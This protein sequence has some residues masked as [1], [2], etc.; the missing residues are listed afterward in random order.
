MSDKPLDPRTTP[1][2]ELPDALRWQLRALRR[3]TPPARDLWS[4]I[5]ARLGE[6]ASPQ[7]EPAPVDHLAPIV[8]SPGDPS[9]AEAAPIEAVPAPQVI[10]LRS[11]ESSRP[12]WL[13]PM[14]LAAS[15]A[16]LAVAL[17]VMWKGGAAVDGTAAGDV[18]A[19]GGAGDQGPSAS[20]GAGIADVGTKPA[21]GRVVAQ[22]STA[23]TATGMADAGK[24]PADSR[25]GDRNSSAPTDTG[26][27]HAAATPA[28]LVQ[29]EADG[30]TRQ[31]QAA[32]REIEPVSQQAVALK[33][34]FDELD[35]NTA[36][37]LDAMAHDPDSRLLLEQLRRTYA[38][39]LA[40][41][42]RVAYT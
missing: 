2:G 1:D 26:I 35:R 36:L 29:R 8:A 3:D 37:I 18:A 31:Y 41:A 34:A 11:R 15:V 33:P 39:R 27:A 6:Q 10:V 12:R 22:N 13:A 16:V 17:G 30:M 4:G 19:V 21:D 23:S 25:A 14:A 20:R 28:S 32:M 9:P 7:D 24:T 40:L 38:R 5:A 42:Q